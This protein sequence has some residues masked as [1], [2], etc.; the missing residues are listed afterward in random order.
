MADW[1]HV[2]R[3]GAVGVPRAAQT[4][5]DIPLDHGDEL[6]ADGEPLGAEERARI[7]A[8]VNINVVAPV[9][10]VPVRGPLRGDVPDA[11]MAA[12]RIAV[13][14]RD[15]IA[16]AGGSGAKAATQIGGIDARALTFLESVLL[17]RLQ[18][19]SSAVEDRAELEAILRA[20]PRRGEPL[21]VQRRTT[22][23]VF[24]Y[25]EKLLVEGLLHV[26]LRRKAMM[27][28]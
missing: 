13:A 15:D 12:A 6:A 25:G 4:T 17:K 5:I 1:P 28:Q 24:R 7:M 3:E 11:L 20:G 18:L 16:D 9:A 23:L 21:S 2:S 22:A 10:Q 14:T 8:E 27:K 19:H 26:T